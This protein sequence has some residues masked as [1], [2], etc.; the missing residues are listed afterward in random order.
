MDFM[1]AKPRKGEAQYRVALVT[2]GCDKNRLDSEIML[3]LLG[4]KYDLVA[5]PEEAEIIIINT[6]G[7]IEA[8]K[9]ESIEAILTM[10][11]LKEEGKCRLLMATGCLTQRYGEELLREIPELDVIL[12]VN[13]YG[14]LDD[15][16]ARF[17]E[18]PERILDI[19]WDETAV[20]Q[21]DRILTT[22][23][24]TTAYLRIGEGCD[25]HCTYC[26]IPK[27]RGRYRSRPQT[28]VVAEAR[29]LVA[30]GVKEI[31][32]VA[33]DLTKY[34]EDLT[35]KKGLPKLLEEL[36]SLEGLK[37]IRLLYLY[38][39][40]IDEDLLEVVA[41]EDKVLPYFDLPIQHI[42]DSVLKRMARQTNRQEIEAIIAAIRQK[43]PKAILRTSL[44]A[45]FPGETQEEF[46]QLL[47]WLGKI[48]LDKVGVFTYSREEGT[49]AYHMADQVAEG[50]K[51]DR[52]EAL[53]FAQQAISL[54]KN[55]EKIGRTYEV[56]IEG[57]NQDYYIGRNFEMAPEIDGDF[58][59]D[60]DKDLVAGQWVTARVK[61]A[62][63]Y[64]LVGDLV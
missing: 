47:D 31:I 37:W 32:L 4:K 2:L 39:E 24:G 7:F 51:E 26:I 8:A 21:G 36:A 12:G 9:E 3:G 19:A 60:T 55:R 41:K 63:E 11:R 58:Y 52:R 38:P 48:K 46:N 16:V 61:E 25:N 57:R 40:G 64:D 33:Q 13:S 17:L 49:P 6:C 29:R 22:G 18:E 45:G 15:Y 44:I 56:L 14:R 5:D 53:M 35:G 50:V 1:I 42:A 43:L 30:G 54:E 23:F 34:G 59:I 27:I 28:E 10:A 62:W 20:N